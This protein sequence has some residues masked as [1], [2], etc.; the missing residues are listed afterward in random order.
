MSDDDSIGRLSGLIAAF[1]AQWGETSKKLQ[2]SSDERLD[3]ANAI[4]QTLGRSL[5][6]LTEIAGR[7]AELAAS[8]G[9]L[10]KR[11]L[12]AMN[13]RL[14]CIRNDRDNLRDRLSEAQDEMRRLTD[15]CAGLRLV[16]VDMSRGGHTSV[17]ATIGDITSRSDVR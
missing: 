8:Q 14:V 6:N 5:D 16:I 7:N 10:S 3:R 2:E 12:D 9:E 11:S 13:D 4:V 15:L 17:S 1:F